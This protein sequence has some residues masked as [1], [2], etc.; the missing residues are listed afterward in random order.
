MQFKNS[1]RYAAIA[2][3][4]L[5][6]TGCAGITPEAMKAATVNYHL[7]MLPS[8]GNAMI[9]VV[10]PASASGGAG[11]GGMFGNWAH[12]TRFNVFLDN[13]EDGSEMGYNRS[14]EYVYFAVQPGVHK[15]YSKAENWAEIQVDAKAGDIIFIRQE[16]ALGIIMARNDLSSLQEYE[17]KYHVK[18]LTLGTILKSEK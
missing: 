10:R 14:S 16:P 2:C 4:A 13:Q 15:I 17:G 6:I 9:Y 7:P 8:N 1:I 11:V 18:T 3:L 5:V 12:L